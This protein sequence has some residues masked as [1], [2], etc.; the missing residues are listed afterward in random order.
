MTGPALSRGGKM[1]RE[2]MRDVA[3]MNAMDPGH[4]SAED[5]AAMTPLERRRFDRARRRFLK[6]GPLIFTS[7]ANDVFE[8]LQVAI[9]ADEAGS[10]ESNDMLL[11]SG[12]AGVGKSK[13]ANTLAAWWY[14]E[15]I[16]F[17]ADDRGVDPQ[18]LM[19][20]PDFV[21]V[22][23]IS[24]PGAVTPRELFELICEFLDAPIGVTITNLR[25]AAEHALREAGTRLLVIDEVQALRFEGKSS[26]DT[27]NTLRHFV[28][29]SGL[30]FVAVGHMMVE[31]LDKP[32][33]DDQAD[34]TRVMLLER[35]TSFQVGPLLHGTEERWNEWV[36]VLE[37][38]EERF[39]LVA[40][41]PGWLSDTHAAYVYQT[42]LGYFKPL[43]SLLSRANAL[44]IDTGKEA[45]DR[46]ILDRSPIERGKAVGRTRRVEMLDRG[47]WQ[48]I[49]PRNI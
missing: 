8:Q 31:I 28:N 20:F 17:E 37:I 11:L 4:V 49:D 9:K 40:A 46:D 21:P 47:L 32:L 38:L 18:S 44:A 16:H 5:L 25:R 26:R 22:V 34:K 29:M 33:D 39:R 6:A 12:P 42:T 36:D 27:H 43:I 15:C 23:R 7:L 35:T 10:S 48:F 3:Q 19:E 13:I 2:W 45:V 30:T 24:L 14:Y 1:R 41:E